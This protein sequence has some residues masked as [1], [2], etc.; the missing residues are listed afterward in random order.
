MQMRIFEDIILGSEGN[1][2]FVVAECLD[3]E[4]LIRAAQSSHRPFYYES[5]A[6]YYLWNGVDR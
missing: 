5:L 1:V 2:R 6:S 3:P 4:G